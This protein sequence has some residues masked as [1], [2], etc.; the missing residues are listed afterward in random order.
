MQVEATGVYRVE[1]VAE[2]FAVSASTIYRAIQS[3][4]L[5]ALKLGTGRG[6]WRVSGAAVLAYATL[7]VQAASTAAV[8]DGM[9]LSAAQADGLACVVCSADFLA[10]GASHVPVGRSASG[11]QVFACLGPCEKAAA[12][13]GL[14]GVT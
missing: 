4:Q 14:E 3:G 9:G 7:C 11:S 2:H 8:A 1:D 13:A 5:D 12:P 10:G 6:T